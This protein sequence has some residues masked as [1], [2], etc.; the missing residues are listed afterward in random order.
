MEETKKGNFLVRIFNRI[1]KTWER[2][3]EPD[4]KDSFSD[5]ELNPEE[6]KELAK[7]K[8]AEN[9][10]V[11]KI[12]GS[13]RSRIKEEGPTAEELNAAIERA[14]KVAQEKIAQREKTK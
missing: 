4:I 14:K 7:V 2:L 12:E 5:L 1:K 10:N 11:E 9:G 3:G 6:E 13:I 8:K